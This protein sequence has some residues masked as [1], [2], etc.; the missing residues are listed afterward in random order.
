[1]NFP[2]LVSASTRCPIHPD[3]GGLVPSVL[4]GG[5]IPAN[6]W[7]QP[8]KYG[9][10][11]PPPHPSLISGLK[12]SVTPASGGKWLTGKVSGILRGPEGSLATVSKA[13][14]CPG[15]QKEGQDSSPARWEMVADDGSGWAKAIRCVIRSFC[16]SVE[17][18]AGV[19]SLALL[20]VHPLCR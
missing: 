8:L 10:C 12:T 5:G 17:F 6:S 13:A 11:H 18:L 9:L 1:M 4:D 16:R 20:M 14:S 3:S 15:S 7:D 2:P 19:A